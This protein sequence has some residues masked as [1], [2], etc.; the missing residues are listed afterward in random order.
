MNPATILAQLGETTALENVALHW[1][2]S[3]AEMPAD[4]LLRGGERT[5]NAKRAFNLREGA[6]RADDRPPAKFVD[7][8][9]TVAGEQRTPL[10]K[11]TFDALVDEYYEERG[12]T[13]EGFIGDQK[14][15][16]LNLTL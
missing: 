1:E 7:Q 10:G 11:E 14:R 15:A 9:L 3:M 2:V 16:E 5:L 13:Q 4:G 12:W 8:A 6:T